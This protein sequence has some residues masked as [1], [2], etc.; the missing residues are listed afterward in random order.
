MKRIGLYYVM[1][2]LITSLFVTSC[3]ND[4]DDNVC[5][6][7]TSLQVSSSQVTEIDT[8]HHAVYTDIVINAPVQDV[9]NVLTD[10]ANMPNWSTSFQG[11]SGDIKDGGQVVATFLLPDPT[12][13]QTVPFEFPHELSY[14]EG[15]QFGWSD[16]VAIAP[17]ITDDHV[18]MLQAISDCQTR[19][20][21]TDEFVGNDANFTTAI[22]AAGSEAGYNQFNLEL[23]T[24]VEK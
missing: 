14:E 6:P 21:Q 8:N 17:G 23:K 12:T 7:D 2:L 4:D 24:E 13:G 10:W 15:V 3:D 16:P 19:L 18:Y 20:I 9:W 22:L 11:L 5:T 1:L